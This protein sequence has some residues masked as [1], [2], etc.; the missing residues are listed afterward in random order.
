MSTHAHRLTSMFAAT[1]LLAACGQAETEVAAEPAAEEA[2]V[3]VAAIEQQIRDRVQ[4]WQQAA[5]T[6]A[7]AFAS[8]YAQD[9]VLMPP[10]GPPAQGAAA[11]T[12]TMTPMMGMVENITFEPVDIRVAESGEMAVERG[13]YTLSGTMQDGSA[14]DDQGS[15]LVSWENQGGE[16][17][18]TNDIF[19]SDRP[20]P[21][22]E[23]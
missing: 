10:N 15:Y 9:G 7:E 20:M 14:F 11:I 5:N 17:M 18:V 12:E 23:Q 16:W 6:S 3:D 21:G 19:N 4:A 22:A 13:R 2:A 8:F 1:L